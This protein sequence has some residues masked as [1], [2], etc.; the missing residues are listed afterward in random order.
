MKLKELK[1]KLPYVYEAIAHMFE[2][3]WVSKEEYDEVDIKKENWFYDYEWTDEQENE[4]KDW[5][6][7]KLRWNMEWRKEIMDFPIRKKDIIDKTVNMFVMNY[8]FKIKKEDS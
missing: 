7:R 3:I 1:D 2:I 6:Y 8:W 4:Y 5:L